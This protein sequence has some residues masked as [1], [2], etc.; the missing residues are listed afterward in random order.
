MNRCYS[1]NP[2]EI[3]SRDLSHFHLEETLLTPEI[4]GMSR[5]MPVEHLA[6]IGAGPAGLSAANIL[7]QLGYRI[8]LFEALPRVGGLLAAG[9]PTY[10]C[11]RHLR[12]SITQALLKPEIRLLLN[13]TV[14]RDIPFRQIQDQFDG[15]LLAIGAHQSVR[16]NIS[17][18]TLLQGV[19]PAL[20]FLEQQALAARRYKQRTIAVIGGGLA[21]LD[22]A[23]QAMRSGAECVRVFCPESLAQLPALAEEKAAALTE[24]VI[25]YTHLLP[26]GILG[27]E[28][29]TVSGLHCERVRC[30]VDAQTRQKPLVSVAGTTC[31]Y[32]ADLVISAFA[33]QPDLS[34]LPALSCQ[35][36]CLS[37][38]DEYG[39]LRAF[40]GTFVAGDAAMGGSHTIHHAI[41]HG[42]QVA[43][44]IDRYFATRALL[45]EGR[46]KKC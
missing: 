42:R 36:D 28:D 2:D 26:V 45:M 30:I 20:S 8:T 24:G 22:V 7:V 10:R 39:S 6:I 32:A 11:P 35:P 4:S 40:P 9:I 16:L 21:T 38:R 41:A 19:F 15:V 31:Y 25:F 43:H 29:V 46:A 37:E 5:R 27:N 33:E 44:L 17:G 14:G 23:R 13:T 12:T 1:A 18:E 34:G 3:A